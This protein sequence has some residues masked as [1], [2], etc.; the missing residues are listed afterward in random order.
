MWGEASLRELAQRFVPVADDQGRLNGDCASA[1]YLRRVTEQGHYGG[2]YR[3]KQGIYCF[4]PSGELLGSTAPDSADA[5]LAMME[6]SLERWEALPEERRRAPAGLDPEEG[7]DDSFPAEGLVLRVVARDLEPLSRREWTGGAADPKRRSVEAIAD[8]GV[9]NLDH[10]WFAPGEAR[11]WIDPGLAPGR[12]H[13]VPDELVR[14]LATVHLVDSVNGRLPMPFRPEEVAGSR[15]ATEIVARSGTRVRVRITGTTHAHTDR[16]FRQRSARSIET[17]LFGRAEFDEAL[18]AFVSFDL[19]ALG[20]RA[21]FRPFLYDS[22]WT[23]WRRIGFVLS[24]DDRA[25]PPVPPHFIDRYAV[26]WVAAPPG[27]RK[28]IRGRTD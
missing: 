12:R 20:L 27:G 16:D 5:V 7:W 17:R 19:V 9:W 1:A 8:E 22:E 10:A 23:D 25:Q 3:T 2:S 28:R 18:G 11:Q 4:A 15:I 13:D 24:L 14:R 6:R 21:D 26:G